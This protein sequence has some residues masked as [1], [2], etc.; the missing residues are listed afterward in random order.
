MRNYDLDFFYK[1]ELFVEVWKKLC[2]IYY[3]IKY[4]RAWHNVPQIIE[5]LAILKSNF[6]EEGKYK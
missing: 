1:N 6:K 3:A 5:I 4:K 2:D